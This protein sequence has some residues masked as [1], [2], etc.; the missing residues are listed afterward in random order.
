MRLR[1]AASQ[2]TPLCPRAAPLP[3]TPGPGPGERPVRCPYVARARPGRSHAATANPSRGLMPL[4][5]N[6]A[7]GSPSQ[8]RQPGAPALRSVRGGARPPPTMMIAA[9]SHGCEHG[10]AWAWPAGGSSVTRRLPLSERPRMARG[11]LRRGTGGLGL[12]QP[13]AAALRP[14]HTRRRPRSRRLGAA[15]P[16]PSSLLPRQLTRP[17]RAALS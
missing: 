12:R 1:A 7:T 14:Q 17:G 2:R 11:R 6:G 16:G 4:S 8:G 3:V 13:P 10:A 9:P 15:S 5:F